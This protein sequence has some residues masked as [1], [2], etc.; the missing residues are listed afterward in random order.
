MK[1]DLM[2]GLRDKPFM[3]MAVDSKPA[4]LAAV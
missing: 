4:E 2:R 3:L 1:H